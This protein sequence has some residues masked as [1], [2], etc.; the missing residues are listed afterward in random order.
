MLSERE[1]GEKFVCFI[2]EE[3]F[4]DKSAQVSIKGGT[5]RRLL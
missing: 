5:D 2:P 3:E 4:L 1:S